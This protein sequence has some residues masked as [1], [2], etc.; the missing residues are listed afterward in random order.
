MTKLFSVPHPDSLCPFDLL[1]ELK[2]TIEQCLS[3]RGTAWDIDVNRDD[4]IT[5][6]NDGVGVVVVATTIGTAV[7][8]EG[9]RG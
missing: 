3:G 6:T 2:Q 9:G 4:T 5:P 7:E 1:L 8:G